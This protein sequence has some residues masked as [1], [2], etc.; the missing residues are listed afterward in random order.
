MRV[1]GYDGQVERNTVGSRQCEFYWCV[2]SPNSVSVRYH[3]L[4][5]FHMGVQ[6]SPQPFVE[7]GRGGGF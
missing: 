3:A 7:E 2:G 5:I 6:D 4:K 1:L